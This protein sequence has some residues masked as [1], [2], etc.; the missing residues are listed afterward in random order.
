MFSKAWQ[1]FK[2]ARYVP[3]NG[4]SE[5][6]L[7]ELDVSPDYANDHDRSESWRDYVKG[8]RHAR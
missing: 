7:S 3:D 8:W 4:L 2:D 6:L 5:T 1:A